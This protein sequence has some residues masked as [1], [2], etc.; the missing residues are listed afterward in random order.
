MQFIPSTWSVVGVDAD[1]DSR[2]NPQDIDDAALATAVYLCSGSEDLSSRAGQRAAAYQYNH[3]I[4][5]VRLVLSVAREYGRTTPASSTPFTAVP[6]TTVQVGDLP[7]ADSTDTPAEQQSS[8]H[9]TPPGQVSATQ[10][11][12]P[13]GATGS[14]S[15]TA[16]QTTAAPVPTSMPPTT[17][18]PSPTS[19]SVSPSGTSPTSNA[20]SSPT[21]PN[22]ASPNGHLAGAE[23]VDHLAVSAIVSRSAG[24]EDGHRDAGPVLP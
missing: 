15:P 4:G 18:S 6:F 21:A 7:G 12:S 10:T 22:Q 24:L 1:G 23:G 11:K 20:T 8:T 17:I 14:P 3:D 19:P 2:R 16:D 13:H 5:Y 9:A